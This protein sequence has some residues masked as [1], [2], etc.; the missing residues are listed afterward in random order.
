MAEG[1]RGHL[2]WVPSGRRMGCADLGGSAGRSFSK[3]KGVGPPPCVG[4]PTQQ[5]WRWPCGRWGRRTEGLRG[6]RLRV[7]GWKVKREG[8][9]AA[10]PGQLWLPSP[11]SSVC[12]VL[13]LGGAAELLQMLTSD[14]PAE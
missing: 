8:G 11:G 4:R 14:T 2:R 6:E 3:E 12:V 5:G 1:G 7:Q 13:T 9:V 10:R